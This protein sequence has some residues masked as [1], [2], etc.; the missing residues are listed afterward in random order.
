MSHL[1]KLLFVIGIVVVGNY[2]VVSYLPP[3]PDMAGDRLLSIFPPIWESASNTH[4]TD[5]GYA[6]S[7]FM[8]ALIVFAISLKKVETKNLLVNDFWIILLCLA[9]IIDGT[10]LMIMLFLCFYVVYAS[11]EL[12][13]DELIVTVPVAFF[14]ILLLTFSAFVFRYKSYSPDLVIEAIIFFALLFAIRFLKQY[15]SNIKKTIIAT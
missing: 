10:F 1:S 14:A 4:E 2:L 3:V 13:N 6:T 9:F 8:V 11:W 15:H 7:V 5:F 12:I